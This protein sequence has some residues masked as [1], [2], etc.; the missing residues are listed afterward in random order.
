MY[1]AS[2]GFC[3]NWVNWLLPLAK[4]SNKELS[5]PDRVEDSKLCKLS[6]AFEELEFDWLEAF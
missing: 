3:K 1:L 6:K 2:V 5:I 4:D